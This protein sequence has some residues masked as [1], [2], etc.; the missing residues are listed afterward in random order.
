MLDLT[1]EQAQAACCAN[2]KCAGFS[3]SNGA[4]VWS[5]VI[6][7]NASVF[8]SVDHMT[9]T[10]IHLSPALFFYCLVRALT[11]CRPC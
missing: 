3:F 6:F 5:V 1:V 11:V 7:K 8:H 2:L 4:L 9:S 10:F